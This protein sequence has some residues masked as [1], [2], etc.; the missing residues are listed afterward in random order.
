ML[1]I[2]PIQMSVA[3]MKFGPSYELI[4]NSTGMSYREVKN[5]IESDEA[6]RRTFKTQ[7]ARLSLLIRSTEGNLTKISEETG[8]PRY[9]VE[10]IVTSTAELQHLYRDER[11]RMVDEAED[12]LRSAMRSG[13]RWAVELTLNRL[14]KSRGWSESKAVEVET[15]DDWQS[16]VRDA[17]AIATA[18]D[19]DPE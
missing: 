19:V 9:A 5:A 3:I 13:K 2:T 8:W 7:I 15:I 16:I 14:G 6:L 11:E 1:S 10:Y 17:L 12:Q 18:I 4:S